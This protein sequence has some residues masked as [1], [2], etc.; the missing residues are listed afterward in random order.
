MY[1]LGA[2][3]VPISWELMQCP[4]TKMKEFR[5]VARPDNV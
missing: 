2:T 4:K 5:K 3:M 1:Y